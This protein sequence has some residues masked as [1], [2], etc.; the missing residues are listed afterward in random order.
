MLAE[1]LLLACT[2]L[3]VQR[4]AVHWK[5]HHPVGRHLR[6]VLRDAVPSHFVVL[7]ASNDHDDSVSGREL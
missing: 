7:D 2:Q 4:I 1:L 5:L 3:R 6:A